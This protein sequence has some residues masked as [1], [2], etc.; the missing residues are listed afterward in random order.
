MDR[1]NIIK[2][3]AI[4]IAVCI[5]FNTLTGLYYN[6]RYKIRDHNE[7][8]TFCNSK[9]LVYFRATQI[10]KEFVE[11]CQIEEGKLISCEEFLG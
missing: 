3:C 9:G 6:L 11:C 5:L 8:E 7:R 1:I 4:I 2:I 10:S